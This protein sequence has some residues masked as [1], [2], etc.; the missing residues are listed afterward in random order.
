MDDMKALKPTIFV[1]V[2]RILTR[3][4][5]K[6]QESLQH[7]GSF[8]KWLFNR[9]ISSKAYNYDAYGC[10]NHPIYDR[11]VLRSVKDIFGG[12][13]RFMVSASAPISAEVLAFFKVALG[14]H[15]YES[16]GQTETNGPA[17]LTHPLDHS[18]GTVGGVV[19]SMRIRLRDLP[20]LGYMSTDNP[21]RGEV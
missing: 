13:V 17:T 8:T 18:H 16:Y 12:H 1:T 14:I 10:L 5:G 21:P 2:P 9:A 6:V 15:I 7:K 19:P 20:E 3:V 4:Y 11:F